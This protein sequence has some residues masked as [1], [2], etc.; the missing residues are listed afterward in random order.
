MNDN[1]NYL[2]SNHKWLPLNQLKSQKIS[3]NFDLKGNARRPNGRWEPRIDA[4]M[5]HGGRCDKWRRDTFQVPTLAVICTQ[6]SASIKTWPV[7]KG[8]YV[9][10]VM[11]ASGAVNSELAKVSTALS[12]WTEFDLA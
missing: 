6:R 11:T 12:Y 4:A 2:D 5:G 10:A 8:P 7:P 9:A 3:L 1:V